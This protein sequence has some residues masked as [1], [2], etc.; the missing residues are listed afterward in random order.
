VSALERGSVDRLYAAAEADF[1]HYDIVKDLIDE[2][3]DLQLNYRE[4]GHPRGS[5]SKVHLLAA[6]G[7][8]R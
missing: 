3:I 2:L 4:F 6:A 1:K 8:N 7:F 5:R